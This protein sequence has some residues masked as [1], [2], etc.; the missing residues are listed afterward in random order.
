MDI[1]MPIMDGIQATKE[2]RRLE[3]MKGSIGLQMGEWSFSRES[4]IQPSSPYHSSVIVALTASSLPSDRIEALAAGCND[5]LT[6]PPDL[7]SLSEK[8]MQWGSVKALQWADM[9]PTEVLA[10]PRILELRGSMVAKHLHIPDGR[11]GKRELG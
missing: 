1:H 9:H 2:I 5:Y 7:R 4:S 10:I 3:K 8:I 11:R 6:K